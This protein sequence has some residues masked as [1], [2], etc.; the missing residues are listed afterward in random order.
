MT[1]QPEIFDTQVPDGVFT[2]TG[3]TGPVGETGPT[4]ATG[5]TGEV[6]ETGATGSSRIDNILYLQNE[7]TTGSMSTGITGVAMIWDNTSSIIDSDYSHS[8]STTDITINTTGWYRIAVACNYYNDTADQINSALLDFAV[9]RQ[10][11]GSG[12][13]ADL[14]G[15]LVHSSIPG[16]TESVSKDWNCKTYKVVMFANLTA[17]DVLRVRGIHIAGGTGVG[18]WNSGTIHLQRI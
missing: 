8:D 1:H 6:G 5:A 4:G 7:A 16:N 9:Q 17:T 12:D 11:L 2:P 3:P 14:D 15:S 18:K 13:F 10:P